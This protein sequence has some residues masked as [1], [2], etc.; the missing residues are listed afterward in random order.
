MGMLQ[1]TLDIIESNLTPQQIQI[2]QVHS[3]SF[4]MLDKVTFH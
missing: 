4:F 2:H 3:L 1:I